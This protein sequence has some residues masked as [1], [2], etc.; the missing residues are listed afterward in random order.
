MHECL[1]LREIKKSH[2]RFYISMA[3]YYIS[4]LNC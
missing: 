4:K 3:K 1:R 2:S